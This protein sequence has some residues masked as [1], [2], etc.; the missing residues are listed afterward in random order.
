M[1]RV[2]GR[3]VGFVADSLWSSRDQGPNDTTPV[4]T[5]NGPQHRLLQ[6]FVGRQRCALQDTTG[7]EGGLLLSLTLYGVGA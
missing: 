3:G 2:T 5:P 7:D 4:F 1:L 6:V